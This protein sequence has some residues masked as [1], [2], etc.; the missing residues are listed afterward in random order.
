M[1]KKSISGGLEKKWSLEWTITDSPFKIQRLLILKYK[2]NSGN[3][4]SNKTTSTEQLKTKTISASL[5][6]LH[7]S[8][9][10]TNSFMRITI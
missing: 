4:K 6:T 9:L 8:I 3:I 10:I 7:K 1:E 5:Q 2:I